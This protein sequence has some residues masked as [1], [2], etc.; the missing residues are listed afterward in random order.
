VL[1][2]LVQL[3]EKSE[4]VTLNGEDEVKVE[5]GKVEQTLV[6]FVSLQSLYQGESYVC[7]SSIVFGLCDRLFCVR[8]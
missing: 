2:N 6:G 7:S 8:F 3:R 5:L 4:E 1:F